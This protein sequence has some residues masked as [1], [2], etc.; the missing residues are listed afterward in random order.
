M[1]AAPASPAEV[2]AVEAFVV[3]LGYY[4]SVPAVMRAVGLSRARVLRA[5]A[6]SAVVEAVPCAVGVLVGV[7]RAVR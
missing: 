2:A 3:P 7:P 5:V 6:A 1:S 4:A